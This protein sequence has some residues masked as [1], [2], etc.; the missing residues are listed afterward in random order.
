[1]KVCCLF[2]KSIFGIPPSCWAHV[3][4][5]SLEARGRGGKGGEEHIF[6]CFP[7]L[8]HGRNNK[9]KTYIS[10]LQ[11]FPRFIKEATLRLF[12]FRFRHAR[13]ETK[14]ARKKK[15]RKEDGQKISNR[16]VYLKNGG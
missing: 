2:L 7:L 12:S 14:Q 16:N 5:L 3:R 15:K 6:L 10:A 11:M 8:F 13:R 4:L 9:K 1:M